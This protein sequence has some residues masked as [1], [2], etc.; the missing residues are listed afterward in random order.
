MSDWS[1]IRTNAELLT[2]W[3]AKKPP[4][5]PSKHVT[6]LYENSIIRLGM[7]QRGDWGIMGCTPEFRSFAGKYGRT[8][9]CV[10]REE[11]PFQAFKSLCDPIPE[12]YF[13]AGDWLEVNLPESFD[14]ILADGVMGML[15]TERYQGFFKSIHRMLKHGGHAILRIM[16]CDDPQFTSPAEAIKWYRETYQG[17]LPLTSLRTH[18][19]VHWADPATMLVEPAVYI[20]HLEELYQQKILTPEEYDTFINFQ[21]NVPIYIAKQ[22]EILSFVTDDFEIITIE[23]PTD[24]LSSR[25][26]PIFTIRKK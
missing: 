25:H 22:Q 11:Q 9:T 14:L 1:G 3:Q 10:D 5:R 6:E 15:P 23:K 7:H 19:L 8:V 13:V 4:A 12:E 16:V 17:N 26:Y 20:R 18:F 24:L 21:L 2:Y